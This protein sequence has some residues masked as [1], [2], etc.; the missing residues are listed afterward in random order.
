MREERVGT[1]LV[2]TGGASDETTHKR[3]VAR[4]TGGAFALAYI[5][6]SI[7]LCQVVLRS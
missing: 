2:T 4:H 1:E 6:I 3:I 5:G 7:H